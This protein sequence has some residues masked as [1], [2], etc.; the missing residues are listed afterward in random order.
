M[1]SRASFL[2][3]LVLLPAALAGQARLPYSLVRVTV[4]DSLGSHR[5]VGHLTS[6]APDSL[7]LRVADS[8]S[9]VGID[10]H[11]LVRVERH[12]DTSVHK[13]VVLGCLAV[14][15]ILGLAGSQVEDP[16]SPGIAKYVA[17]YGSLF[18]CALGALGGFIIGSL[19]S[20]YA[21]EEIIV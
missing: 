13:A 16:D 18:G 6:I 11:T 17:V 21:W 12:V 19:T 8:D 3:L 1:L 7:V 10:R 9:L 4:R 5:L 20:H 14:G 15:A 2:V